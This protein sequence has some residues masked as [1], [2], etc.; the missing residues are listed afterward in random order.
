[1][2]LDTLLAG[3]A[4]RRPD[5]TA[6]VFGATRDGML[7]EPALAAWIAGGASAGL[8]DFANAAALGGRGSG[9]AQGPQESSRQ[10]PRSGVT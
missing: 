10:P 4:L 1:M 8:A 6:L 3:H 2:R 9:R 5:H 7:D